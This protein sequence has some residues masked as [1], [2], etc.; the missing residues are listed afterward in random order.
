MGL[1]TKTNP[2][3]EQ[4]YELYFSGF[5]AGATRFLPMD[6]LFSVAP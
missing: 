1:G 5:A 4:R 2:Q 6:S 3:C